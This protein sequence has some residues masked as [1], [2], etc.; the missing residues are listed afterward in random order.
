MILIKSGKFLMGSDSEDGF[1]YDKEG[2]PTLIEI[3][4]F[5][6]DETS[7]TNEEFQKF[8]NETNYITEAEKFGNSFVFAALLTDEERVKYQKADLMGIWFD[9]PGANWKHPQGPKSNIINKMNY[10]V[11][12][13]SLYD[14]IEYCK[15]SGKRLPTEAEWE[16]A[17]RGGLIQNK[18]SWGNEIKQNNKY[19]LNIWNGDFPFGNTLEDGF[20]DLAP[21]KSFE[22][23]GYGVYQMLGNIW[24]WCINT[25]NV[26]LEYFQKNKTNEIS[27]L[28]INENKDYAIRGGSYLCHDGFCKRYKVY[29]RNGTAPRST[30][31]NMG[32]RCVKDI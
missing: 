13:V 29:S 27:N 25:K 7:V 17:A 4:G 19:N 22:P 18:F 32:F 31:G 30:A 14:A 11:V 6:I 2:P 26:S 10:P 9:V 24:E 1:I 20:L 15:W 5:Y 23:N 28:E 12:H 21:A 8:I 3:N 16:Y